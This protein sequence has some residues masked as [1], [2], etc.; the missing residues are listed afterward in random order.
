MKTVSEQLIDLGYKI[1]KNYHGYF[2]IYR[3]GYRQHKTKYCNAVTARDI[4][5][6]HKKAG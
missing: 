4:L 1:S 2:C 3:D 6:R 5:D